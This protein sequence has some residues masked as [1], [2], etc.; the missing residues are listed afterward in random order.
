MKPKGPIFNIT[1]FNYGKELER[2][3]AH[4]ITTPAD[5]AFDIPSVIIE[6][7]ASAALARKKFDPLLIQ[8]LKTHFLRWQRLLELDA[9][10]CVSDYE[11]HWLP[12]LVEAL[13]CDLKGL[14]FELSEEESAWLDLQQFICS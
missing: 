3:H 10:A 6:I 11:Y 1:P 4:L 13:N 2:L 14:P 7:V 12:R 5:P 9:P 8:D